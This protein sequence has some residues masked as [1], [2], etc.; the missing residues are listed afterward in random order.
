MLSYYVIKLLNW[1]EISK[2]CLICLKETI[3]F[4]HN[5]LN[6]GKPT[7]LSNYRKKWYM[8]CGGLVYWEEFNFLLRFLYLASIDITKLLFFLSYLLLL[9]SIALKGNDWSKF[10]RVLKNIKNFLSQSNKES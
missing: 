4:F 8:N 6:L 5:F 2:L 10:L 7:S 9:I 1:I 3:K